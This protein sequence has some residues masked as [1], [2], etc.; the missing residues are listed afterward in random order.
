M[1]TPETRSS[2]AG[3]LGWGVYCASSWT[4]CIGM[5]LPVIMLQRY[6]WAGFAVFAVPNVLGCAAFGFVLSRKA[7]AELV[8]GHL[9]AMRWFSVVTVAFHLFFAGLLMTL[10][11]SPL[12]SLGAVVPGLAPGA[13]IFL[14]G[15]ALTQ[16]PTKYWPALAT[17]VY[18]ASLT[19]FGVLLTRGGPEFNATGA[20]PPAELAWLAPAIIWGF[21]ACPYLDL[22][23]HRAR[24]HAGRGAFAVFGLSFA[25]MIVLT[26]FYARSLVLDWIILAHLLLQSTFTVGAHLREL[27]ESGRAA[28]G[29]NTLM[30]FLPLAALLIVPLLTLAPDPEDAVTATYLRFMVFYGLVFPA[31]VVFFVGPWRRLLVVPTNLVRFGFAVLVAA[32]FYELGFI[33]HQTWLI[34]FPVAGILLY[35][36][37]GGF[38]R[39]TFRLQGAENATTES[40]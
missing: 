40:N 30:I 36:W 10:F 3:A 37:Q 19:V 4:W 5:F 17:F 15:L 35:A 33:A 9:G 32:P 27:R 1:N 25:V 8:I 31:Y 38:G 11:A 34:V 16:L 22:T 26:T 39:S 7:S 12:L 21:L 28:P 29:S 13:A 24:Q 18:V 20:R 2:T 23:F 14:L 6:G